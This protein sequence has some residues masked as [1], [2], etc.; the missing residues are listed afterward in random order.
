MLV[1]VVVGNVSVSDPSFRRRPE[2]TVRLNRPRIWTPASAGVTVKVPHSLPLKTDTL[3]RRSLVCLAACQRQLGL[4]IIAPEAETQPAP[5]RRCVI[6]TVHFSSKIAAGIAKTGLFI[7]RE[8]VRE[9][10]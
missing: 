5:V 10:E 1:T 8:S 4:P 9:I 3:P 2:S 6:M 7:S